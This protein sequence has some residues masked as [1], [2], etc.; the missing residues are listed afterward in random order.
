MELKIPIDF[1]RMPQVWAL[2]EALRAANLRSGVK[3]TNSAIE[4]TAAILF[5]RLFVMLGYLA[6]TTAQVG[7]LT[8]GGV[9][10]YDASFDQFNQEEETPHEFL[11]RAGLLERSEQGLFCGLFATTNAHLGVN[12][13]SPSQK[14]NRRS[15]LIR[16]EQNLTAQAMQQGMLLGAMYPDRLRK[17]NGDVME[18]GLIDRSAVL[19]TKLDR[20]FGAPARKTESFSAG[21]LADACAI[22]ERIR[23]ESLQEF[24]MWLTDHKGNP[25]L[26]ATAELILCDWDRVFALQTML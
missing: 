1:E 14:G 2:A 3:L 4:Q 13:V 9:L 21:M 8:E 15:A 10:Q 17:R 7:W 5:L 23:P 16:A 6:R 11:V 19:I 12:Y 25:A 20:V 18:Q 22:V 24:Y 26:P